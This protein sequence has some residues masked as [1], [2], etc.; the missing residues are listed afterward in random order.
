MT[1]A[2]RIESYQLTQPPQLNGRG[3]K[4]VKIASAAAYSNVASGR[5]RSVDNVGTAASRLRV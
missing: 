1:V 5:L 3:S 2:A 4:K